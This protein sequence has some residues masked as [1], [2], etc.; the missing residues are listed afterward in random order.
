MHLSL[1][2]CKVR[3]WDWANTNTGIWEY[4]S[5]PLLSE[6]V[7]GPSLSDSK[8]KDGDEDE[9]EE[10]EEDGCLCELLCLQGILYTLLSW[11]DAP[12]WLLI[13]AS[14]QLNLDS[15]IDIDAVSRSISYCPNWTSSACT[16]VKTEKHTK[17]LRSIPSCDLVSLILPGD[18]LFIP[19][20]ISYSIRGVPLH[21]G[22]YFYAVICHSILVWS[23]TQWG[24]CIKVSQQ[25]IP[26]LPA[27]GPLWSQQLQSNGIVTF[28][29]G[30]QLLMWQ[31]RVCHCNWKWPEWNNMFLIHAYI[32]WLH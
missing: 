17:Y 32:T 14:G 23:C 30:L 1:W 11:L 22:C 9:D 8:D 20:T 15:D 5:P 26:P 24:Q 4:G 27:L 2:V 10:E 3:H 18:V 16:A 12:L 25:H 19:H 29:D 13:H 28:I 21:C 7:G 31:L 6:Q